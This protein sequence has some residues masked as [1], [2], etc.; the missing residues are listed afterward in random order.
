MFF[1]KPYN[2]LL[3][4]IIDGVPQ[5]YR[6]DVWGSMG[7]SLL[8]KKTKQYFG[9]EGVKKLQPGTI[10]NITMLDKA[11]VNPL[12]YT[13]VDLFRKHI[14][15]FG[16]RKRVMDSYGV[17]L[18][19]IAKYLETSED[20]SLVCTLLGWMCRMDCALLRSEPSS[21]KPKNNKTE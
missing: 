5:A 21:K 2:R 12:W 9:L 4:D 19:R 13:Q 6:R 7:Y 14:M 20:G 8:T 10:R 11:S 15:Y 18:Y 17:H 16:A 1:R 3:K